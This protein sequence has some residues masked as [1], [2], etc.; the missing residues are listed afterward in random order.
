MTPC[1]GPTPSN[2]GGKRWLEGGVPAPRNGAFPNRRAAMKND[3]L[4]RNIAEV[5][6]DLY[7]QHVHRETMSA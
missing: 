3:P 7:Q 5:I 2:S 4:A 6:D 1:G